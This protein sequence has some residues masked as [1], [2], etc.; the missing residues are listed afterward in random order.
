MSEQRWKKAEELAARQYLTLVNRE[1]DEDGEYYFVAVNPE[2][3]GCRADGDTPDAAKKNLAEARVDFIY[4]LL[5][6]NL[7]VPDPDSFTVQ[8]EREQY[9]KA[10]ASPRQSD[11]KHLDISPEYDQGAP[12]T[13]HVI[14]AQASR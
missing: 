11:P 2:L 8:S 13:D 7:P 14:P 1:T 9:L 4:F 10:N 5:E 6:D 3:P 12:H